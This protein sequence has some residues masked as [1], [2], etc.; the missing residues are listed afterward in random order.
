MKFLARALCTCLLFLMP[1]AALAA[2]PVAFVSDFRG[3]VAMNGAG[4]P[5][6]LAELLPGTRL[7]LGRDGSASVMYVVT[8]EEFSLKGPGEFVVTRQGVKAEKGSAPSSRVPAVKANTA[9]LV[10]TSRAATASLRMRSAPA[11]KGERAGPA[12]PV[13]AK[14]ATLQPT[15]R[16]AGDAGASHSVV[17]TTTAGGEVFR[18]S[19]KGTSIRLPVRLAAGQGYAWTCAAGSGEPAEARFETLPAEAIAAAEKAR[20]AA[21]T[22]PDRVLFAMLLQE[23]GAAQDSREVWA[24][25]AEERPDIPELAG[26]AR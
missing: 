4:R 24:Q 8:G 18:G 11:P 12:Y 16:C 7:V 14:I 25:L 15:L 3:E 2:D 20:A 21:R 6:F 19:V 1:L 5:S 10:Q 13:G 22:F 9:I 17:V 23:I 26:L